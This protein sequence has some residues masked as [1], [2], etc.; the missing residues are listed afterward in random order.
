M[1]HKPLAQI[2]WVSP[3]SSAIH[4]LLK[5]GVFLCSTKA[6]CRA[7]RSKCQSFKVIWLGPAPRSF[8]P[9]LDAP[10]RKDVWYGLSDTTLTKT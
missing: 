6:S 3:S 2:Q 4:W 8:T 1:G 9:I 10:W 7:F 5:L